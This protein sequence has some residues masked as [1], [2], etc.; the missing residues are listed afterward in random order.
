MQA[1]NI[2][3]VIE[4][5]D[6]IAESAQRDGLREGYFALLYA[7]MTR[8]IRD[9]IQAGQFDDGPRMEALDVA[10]ANRYFDARAKYHAGQALTQAWAHTFA[11]T[12]QHKPLIFQHLV[13]GINAHINLDLGVSTASITR[14]EHLAALEAD[15]MRVNQIL[16]SLI[17]GI[18]A[19]I[20][21]VSPLMGALD[22][23]GGKADELWFAFELEKARD[24]AWAV[25]N[26]LSLLPRDQW[27]ARIDRL[28]LEVAERGRLI[29]NPGLLISLAL[30]VVGLFESSDV[31]HNLAELR[32]VIAD[33]AV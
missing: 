21:R 13:L 22:F 9:A 3:Q 23:V 33:V 30:R 20:N 12:E 29:E 1:T 18:Q 17:E 26:Q 24:S 10:F 8:A 4:W 14:P 2:E 32:A 15:F 5:L 11:L 19:A 7:R 6:E 31:R 25:A 27:P 28:D 16:R